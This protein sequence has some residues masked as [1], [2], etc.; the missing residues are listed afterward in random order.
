MAEPRA[1]DRYDLENIFTYHAPFG[2]QQE[3]YVVLRNAGK[4][5][6]AVVLASCPPSAERTLALRKIEEAVM[7][8]N[9]SI[10]RNEKPP[11]E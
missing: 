9:A 10:A 8:A 6:A 2:T 11:A 5:L 7:W 1:A 4:T 3:R